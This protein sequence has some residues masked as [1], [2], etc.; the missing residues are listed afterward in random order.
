MNTEQEIAK[1]LLRDIVMY[2]YEAYI[3]NQDCYCIPKEE[4]KRI[5]RRRSV[6]I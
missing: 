4:L 2:S 6:E 1:E 3:N 5:A